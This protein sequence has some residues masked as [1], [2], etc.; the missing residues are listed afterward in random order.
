MKYYL[1]LD[2]EKKITYN[3]LLFLFFLFLLAKFVYK[4]FII[5]LLIC[6]SYAFKTF[7][8]SIINWPFSLINLSSKYIFDSSSAF[9]KYTISQCILDLFPLSLS[10]RADPGVKWK[11]PTIFSSY[12]VLFTKLC[13]FGFSPI[14]NS[15]IYLAPSSISNIA[16]N[17]SLLISE[18]A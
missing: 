14:A 2:K 17:L 13:I 10:D 16:C 15:P 9:S 6:Y 18:Y 8:S 7:N 3:L 1:K 4:N 12:K 5:F 11:L